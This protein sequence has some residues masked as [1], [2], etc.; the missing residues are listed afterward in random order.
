MS[1]V[2]NPGTSSIVDF[3]QMIGWPRRTKR[4]FWPPQA[5]EGSNNEVVGCNS[6]TDGWHPSP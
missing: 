3:A 1:F 5:L 2:G 4:P 6:K